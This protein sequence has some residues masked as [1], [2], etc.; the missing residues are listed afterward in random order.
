MAPKLVSAL[1]MKRQRFMNYEAP[2]K[3][4]FDNVGWSVNSKGVVVMSVTIVFDMDY[5]EIRE[6]DCET[7]QFH[8]CISSAM[9]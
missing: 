4:Y 7:G 8:E 1:A 6:V 2:Y 9:R 5:L 3:Q